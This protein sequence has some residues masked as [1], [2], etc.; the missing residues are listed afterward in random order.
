MAIVLGGN[1][2]GVIALGGDFPG[3][4]GYCP[5]GGWGGGGGELSGGQLSREQVSRGHWLET[6]PVAF[7]VTQLTFRQ[8]FQIHFGKPI[9]NGNTFK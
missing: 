1:C 7:I 5:G 4:G 2:P 6:C 8:R 3:G 9:L